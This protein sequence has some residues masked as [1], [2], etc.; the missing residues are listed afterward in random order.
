[1]SQ[2]EPMIK[3]NNLSK[4]Y[5]SSPQLAVENLSIEIS[6]GEVYGFLGPNG[7]GKSTLIR[8]LMNFIAPTSG[9]AKISGFDIVRESVEIRQSVGYLSGDFAM[10]PKMT[11]RQY[12]GYMSELQGNDNQKAIKEYSARLNANLD[13]KL[14]ELS[15]G[16]KQKIGI[17]QAFMHQPD[18]LILDE[19]TSGLD[20]LVQEEFL[21][22]VNE[23]SQRGA[24]VLM[25]SHVLSEVQKACDRIGIIRNGKL[26]S[27]KTIAE[28]KT[29][30]AQT[31]DI[32]FEGKVSP[33]AKLKKLSGVKIKG[34]DPGKIS[35]H[36]NGSLPELLKVLSETKI[37]KIDTRNLDL[38]D[39]FIKFYETGEKS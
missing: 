33:I 25:S 27:E 15:R 11:G 14:G 22:M 13:K 19:P 32:E 2:Q 38:E 37:T 16:N 9:Q 35:F 5:G 30:A 1:M 12:L 4:R 7:A 8:M 3:I 18:V 34:Q 39:E 31:F 24:C 36:F 23:A 20:P 17:I 28:L 26:I 21:D 6:S 29:N 10:Y